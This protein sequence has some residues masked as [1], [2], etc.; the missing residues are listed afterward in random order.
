MYPFFEFIW[1]TESEKGHYISMNM[2]HEEVSKSGAEYLLHM[3]DDWHFV[4][5]RNYVTESL[6]ILG[7]DKKIGQVLFNINYAEIELSKRRCGGGILKRAKDGTR[8]Y[9]HE[10]Y[11]TNT[12]EYSNFLERNKGVGTCGYWPHF[13][14]RPSVLKTSMLKE[15]GSFFNTAHFEMQYAIEYTS[16]GYKSAFFDTFCCIH[17]GKKTW[18]NN[19]INSY[20]LNKTGQFTLTDETLFI[21]VI[22]DNKTKEGIERWKEFKE[23]AKDKLPYCIRHI[24]K[25]VNGL[26]S[27]EKKIFY[28]NN[29]NYLRS[30]INKIM[31]NLS[32]FRENKSKY[33]MLLKDNVVLVND[34]N[35]IF[36][37]LVSAIKSKNYDFI[38]LDNKENQDK[39]DLEIIEQKMTVN[40]ETCYGYLISETGIKKI[41]DHIEIN[42]VQNVNY[43]DNMTDFKT[44]KL[45]KSL[46]TIKQIKEQVP[47]SNFVKLEGYTFYSQLDS[48]GHDIGFYGK[49]SVEEYKE[50]CDREGGVC[51]NTLGYIKDKTE[52]EENYIYLPTSTKASDGLY[53]KN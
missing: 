6:K 16:R 50:I 53:V 48:F 13:S 47:N 14:F 1:K 51:F 4:Q 24:P 49:K 22:S 11:D 12:K 8:Y 44:Y 9:I 52:S 18:E 40:L 21:N 34:F 37:K 42:R 31:I 36:P 25:K 39:K 15:V 29:F 5:K 26:D 23:N 10:H 38:M 43:L 17:T 33:M 35:K 30:I 27:F 46:Y 20:H 28:G 7:E 2:I 41:L 32:L 3:E 45:N 19:G